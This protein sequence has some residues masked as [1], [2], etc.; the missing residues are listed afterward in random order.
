M[1]DTQQVQDCR[2]H[3]VGRH[4]VHDGRVANWVGRTVSQAGFEASACEDVRE[5][6]RVVI[7]TFAEF[8]RARLVR[9]ACGQT[10][11]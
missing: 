3:V 5:S 1:V 4:R 6:F 7:A 9:K 11:W 2:V 8:S 10:R